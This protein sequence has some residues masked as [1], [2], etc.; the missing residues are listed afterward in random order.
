MEHAEKCAQETAA[1]R[2]DLD[3]KEGELRQLDRKN[4]ATAGPGADWVVGIAECYQTIDRY[5]KRLG[6][7]GDSCKKGSGSAMV[8]LRAC[9]ERVAAELREQLKE[10]GESGPTIQEVDD[11]DELDEVEV[12]SLAARAGVGARTPKTPEKGR[13]TEAAATGG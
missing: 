3:K 4:R 11:D 2:A 13:Q 12:G 6:E 7:R 10:G 5:A 1:A 8:Q 9:M